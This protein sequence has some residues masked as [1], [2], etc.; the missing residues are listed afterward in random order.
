[1]SKPESEC[2]SCGEWRDSP[3]ADCANCGHQEPEA[4]AG[5]SADSLD[6]ARPP[7]PW[8]TINTD[9]QKWGLWEPV[10]RALIGK[11]TPSRRRLLVGNI[12]SAVA[13]W[14]EEFRDCGC[15][16]K[17]DGFALCDW[18]E[19]LFASQ[20]EEVERLAARMTTDE[21]EGDGQ[22]RAGKP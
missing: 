18:H 5:R 14:R 6:V 17:G 10:D 4:E 20:R 15:W 9:V 16:K 11:F 19:R 22:A 8:T 13:R 12:V 7:V 21:P 2:P 1:M 3:M